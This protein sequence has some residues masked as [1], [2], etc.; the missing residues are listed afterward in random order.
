MFSRIVVGTDGS[1]NANR[2]LEVVRDLTSANPA[3]EVQVVTG[4]RPLSSAQM[5]AIARQLP[6][7]FSNSLHAHVGAESVL[8]MA[9]TVFG[10]SDQKVGYQ[11]IDDDPTDAILDTAERIA[12]D[13]IVVGS[14]GENIAKRAVHGSVST[15]VL[16]H[17]PCSVLVVK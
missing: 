4:Y 1:D 11:E 16:H 17:A 2:A 10:T 8:D 12:A 7:E 3:F 6:D 13:L 5:R 15:K 14:R 9:R